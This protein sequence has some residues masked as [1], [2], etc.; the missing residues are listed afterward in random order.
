MLSSKI[1]SFSDSLKHALA[2]IHKRES[3]YANTMLEIYL[4]ISMKVTYLNY[5]DYAQQ[6][7]SVTTLISKYH[8]MKILGKKE[9]LLM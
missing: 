8:F 7:I 6:T 3:N 4:K 2:N 9:P 5:L 1:D